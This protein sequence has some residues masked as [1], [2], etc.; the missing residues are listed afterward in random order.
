MTRK[1][2]DTF[3]GNYAEGTC[4]ETQDSL[5]QLIRCIN[6]CSLFW[7]IF[8]RYFLFLKT[9]D[10]NVLLLHLTLSLN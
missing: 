3:Q 1:W 6:S 9:I 7:T 2:P 5:D 8:L 10:S 4:T